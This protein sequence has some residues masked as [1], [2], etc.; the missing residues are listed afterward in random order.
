MLRIGV[1]GLGSMGKNHARV[2]SEL[3]TIQLAG[4]SDIDAT[5]VKNIADRFHTK[6]F[7]N[8]KDMIKEIDAA[9]IATPTVTHHKIAMDML[10]QGKH[11]LVEKP[12]CDSVQKAEEM[13][14]KAKGIEK[15][16][17]I[18]KDVIGIGKIIKTD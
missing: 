5:V 18:I 8:H 10:N 3:G 11:V 6:P 16:E 12:I 13:A 4:V 7:Y 17:Y 2:C 14:R 15:P 1:I 9:I